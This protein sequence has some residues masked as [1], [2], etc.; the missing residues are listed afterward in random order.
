M[1]SN[2]GQQCGSEVIMKDISFQIMAAAFE[3]HNVLGPG[4]LENVYEKALLKELQDRGITCEAQKPVNVYFK[5]TEVGSYFVDILVNNEVILELK[6]IEKLAP[7]H[8]AQVLNYLRATGLR[9]GLLINFSKERVEH[10]RL[11]L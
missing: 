2:A 10:K 3:V 7:I 6:A 5:N 1:N 4:F 11:V 8:E 9:L